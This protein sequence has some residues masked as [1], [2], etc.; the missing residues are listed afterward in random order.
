MLWEDAFVCFYLKNTTKT[1]NDEMVWSRAQLDLWKTLAK[2]YRDLLECRRGRFFDA[3]ISSKYEGNESLSSLEFFVH[4]WVGDVI[5]Y[6]VIGGQITLRLGFD[7]D[8]TQ[9]LSFGL[10]I[11]FPNSRVILVH[12][13]L[14][15]GHWLLVWGY[16]ALAIGLSRLPI[17]LG[18]I[19]MG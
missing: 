11:I 15:I 8:L 6:K 12:G 5:I 7:F 10:V 1:T 19:N 9:S 4:F 3:K 2:E 16:R 13:S 18:A 14:I 17:H